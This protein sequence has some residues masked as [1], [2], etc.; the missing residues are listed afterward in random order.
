MGEYFAAQSGVGQYEQAAAGMGEYFAAQG[1][2]EFFAYTPPGMQGLGGPLVNWARQEEAEAG[3]KGIFGLG[4]FFSGMGD[5]AADLRQNEEDMLVCGSDPSVATAADPEAA[6]KGCLA[7]REQARKDAKIALKTF[8]LLAAGG[9]VAM[10][11]IGRISKAKSPALWA[12]GGPVAA[13]AA[14]YMFGFR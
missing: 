4:E 13:G 10:Y 2:G 9:A 7:A 5:A 12:L 3:H 14:V 6:L 11:G 8:A 1:L